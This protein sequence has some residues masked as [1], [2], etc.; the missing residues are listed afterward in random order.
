MTTP[1]RT[2]DPYRTTYHRD[3]SVTVWH[4]CRQQ[5]LRTR[6]PSDETLAS[7][8]PAERTRVERHCEATLAARTE[9]L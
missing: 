7:L 8:S 3:G 6:S 4:V 5:W 9:T 1:V 2:A